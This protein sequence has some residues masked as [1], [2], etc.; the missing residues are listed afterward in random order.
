MKTIL[1]TIIACFLIGT[2]SYSQ[3]ITI[4][5]KQVSLEKAF[6]EIRKQTGYTFVYT[7]EQI[8]KSNPVSINLKDA[9]LNQA[10]NICFTN[11]PLTFIIE[12]KHIIIK[13]RL[14]QTNSLPG[15]AGIDVTGKVINEESEPVV[16]ATVAV[17]GTEMAMATD[18]KGEFGFSNLKINDVLRVTNIGYQSIVIPIQ[19][20]TYVVIRLHTSI[21]ILDETVLIAYGNTTRRFNTGSVTKVTSEEISEQPVLNPLSALQGRVPGLVVTSTSGLPGSSFNIQIRGQNSL[22]PDPYNSLSPKDNPLFIIDGVPYAPQNN[23]I[24]QLR[25]IAS[26][27]NNVLLNNSYGG[28]SPF[29]SINPADIESIVILQDADATAIYGSRGANGVILIT[30]KKGK[31][32]KTKFS[33]NVYSGVSSVAHTLPMMNTKQYLETRREA[34]AN[35]G[36]IPT[37]NDPSNFITYAPDLLI[38][39]TSKYTDWK[40]FFIGNPS[41]TTNINT[42]LSGGSENTQFLLGA[43]YYHETYIYPGDFAYDRASVNM[44]LHHNSV[45]KKLSIDFSS[46]YS[47][48]K[49]NS[50][51]SPNLLAAYSLDPDFPNLLDENGNLLWSYKGASYG[52]SIVNPLS[53]LKTKYSVTNFN[54]I[55]HLQVGYK[56]FQDLEIRASLG[57]N[58]LNSSEYSGQPLISQD[59]AAFYRIASADFGTKNIRNWIIEPQAEYNKLFGKSKINILFGETIEQDINSSTLIDASGYSNDNLITSI[60]GAPDITASDA[61]S[62]YKYNAIF[63][64]VNYM[65]DQRYIINLTG[66]RDGSS[67][68]GPGKQFGNFGSGGVAWIFSEESFVKKNF[69]WL[70]F[71]KLR[72]SYGTTGS[73]AIGDYQYIARWQPSSYSYQGSSGYLPQN[74]F[75]P[76]FS[77]AITKKAEGAIELGFLKDRLFINAT[78]YRNLSGNQLVFYQLPSQTGF[79]NV[80]ENSPA[81]VQNS[82]WEFTLTSSNFKSKNFKWNTSFNITIPKNKLLSFPGIE[83]SSYA[84][85]YIVGQSLNVIKGFKYLSVNDTT[86]VFQFLTAKGVPTYSPQNISGNNFNDIQVIGNLDPKFYGGLSNSFAFK[87]FQ[88]DVFIEFKKQTGVNYLAQIYGVN[89]PGVE[90]NLPTT[91]LSRW[92]KPGDKSEFEKFTTD[93]STAAG[94]AARSYFI[95]SSGVYSDASYIRVK[96]VSFSYNFHG[97][98]LERIKAETLRFYINAQNLFTITNYKGN[99]PETQNFYGVPPLRTIVLG[100]QLNF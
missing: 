21:A 81:K 66:R 25:S 19:G 82:G 39:D 28:I 24:N 44:S 58:Y 67:R 4:S 3:T 100:F 63:G 71:G 94:T 98:Y 64:R 54:L 55:S 61:Y 59:P 60:S 95:E 37:S 84:T 29:S 10:L 93:A 48:D 72:A 2:R 42:S 32:G 40:K 49:N 20:R 80:T 68:F 51:G 57:Y 22:N 23:N 77:W 8:N 34:F 89:V 75:N 30:T 9:P 6:K 50:S 36:V 43:G 16:G 70:S 15:K 86:G 88:L 11:Q 65:F 90:Y 76:D 97:K 56:I 38:Y 85:K 14:D 96:T 79:L 17:E 53:Y 78:F 73:D 91:L 18:S 33:M 35:D 7:R 52:V 41:H 92:Q 83:S 99:D 31:A 62:Q 12:D 69:E 47:F 26:P 45:N 87:N 13:D 46:N 74:L 27:G 1:L 5:L